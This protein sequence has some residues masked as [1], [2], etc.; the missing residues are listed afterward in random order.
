[1]HVLHFHFTPIATS[2]CP[3][4]SFIFYV[5]EHVTAHKEREADGNEY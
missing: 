5:G 1:M 2:A 4:F 3:Y